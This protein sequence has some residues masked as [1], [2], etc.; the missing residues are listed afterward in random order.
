MDRD[1]QQRWS[2]R[3]TYRSQSEGSLPGRRPPVGSAAALS[4]PATSGQALRRRRSDPPAADGASK[5]WDSDGGGARQHRPPRQ[6]SL[7]LLLAHRA[8]SIRLFRRRSQRKERL[9][10]LLCPS[11]APLAEAGACEPLPSSLARR[12]RTCLLARSSSTAARQPGSVR[13]ARDPDARSISTRSCN[14]LGRREVAAM[15]THAVGA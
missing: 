6:S 13:R 1:A 10:S 15:A 12:R 9:C 5:T 4:R 2:R 14:H 7:G 8:L 3:P 11:L